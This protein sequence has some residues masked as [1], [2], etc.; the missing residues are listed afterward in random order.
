MQRSLEG[1]VENGDIQGRKQVS[2]GPFSQVGIDAPGLHP[3][4]HQQM[5]LMVLV[6]VETLVLIGDTLM[7]TQSW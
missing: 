5:R 3:A 7:Q 6:C 4:L 1:F 2:D